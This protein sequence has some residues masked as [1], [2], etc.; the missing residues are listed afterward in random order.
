MSVPKVRH[1][2]SHAD[3]PFTNVPK[4]LGQ[5][6][7]AESHNILLYAF[8][9]KTKNFIEMINEDFPDLT[10]FFNQDGTPWGW[11]HEPFDMYHGT[12]HWG[13]ADAVDYGLLL[14]GALHAGGKNLLQKMFDHLKHCGHIETQKHCDYSKDAHNRDKFSVRKGVGAMGRC[15]F[16]HDLAP[17]PDCNGCGMHWPTDELA[18][19]ILEALRC[20]M[21][22]CRRARYGFYIHDLNYQKEF[23]KVVMERTNLVCTSQAEL[24]NGDP[25]RWTVSVRTALTE[26]IR[27]L[28]K[29]NSL[30]PPQKIAQLGE[31]PVETAHRLMKAITYS[32]GANMGG[33]Q[34][35][36]PNT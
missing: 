24:S 2:A 14:V 13:R 19:D 25:F 21:L 35:N 9:N 11:P 26:R 17:R 1:I 6:Y 8:P 23:T 20:H 32:Q 31:D 5:L 18:L 22:I 33:R 27:L 16:F 7:D 30:T 12:L 4:A 29:L 34:C 36:V 15:Q 28:H 10:D 3:Q